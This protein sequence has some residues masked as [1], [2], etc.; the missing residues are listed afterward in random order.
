MKVKN[1]LSITLTNEQIDSMVVNEL[2]EIY[3]QQQTEINRL[4]SI[5]TELEEYQKQNLEYCIELRNAARVLLEYHLSAEEA[6]Q[7][8]YSIDNYEY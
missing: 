4:Y 1:M 5:I 8:F 6:E 2:K 7:Y 3:E